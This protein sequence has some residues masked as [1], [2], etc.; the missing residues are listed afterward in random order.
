MAYRVPKKSPLKSSVSEMSLNMFE[1]GIQQ[2]FETWTDRYMKAVWYPIMEPK[3][4]QAHT[5][6]LTHLKGVFFL[7]ASGMT[8]AIVA[9]LLELWWFNKRGSRNRVVRY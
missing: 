6:N 1:N 2:M 7:Y 5:L 3:D 9:F 4:S 8:V